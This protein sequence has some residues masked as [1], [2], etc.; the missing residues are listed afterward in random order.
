[1]LHFKYFQ[2]ETEVVLLN[3]LAPLIFFEESWCTE[4]DTPPRKIGLT[5]R[6]PRIFCVLVKD[7]LLVV[8]CFTEVPNRFFV[9]S[10][11]NKWL[12]GVRRVGVQ[13]LTLSI[14]RNEFLISICSGNE[15][16][17]AHNTF[18]LWHQ[19]FQTLEVIRL[20]QINIIEV[21][22]FVRVILDA[23]VETREGIV[24]HVFVILGEY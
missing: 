11:I 1:M 23:L 7:H 20:E 18:F 2:A 4:L 15:G 14:G 6:C 16:R 3:E 17:G 9:Q 24:E 21:N 13:V 5:G 10:V 12:V 22:M 8:I 19:R